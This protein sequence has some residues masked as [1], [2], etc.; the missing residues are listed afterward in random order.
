MM[1]PYALPPEARLRPSSLALALSLS[2]A[3][4]HSAVAQTPRTGAASE[5]KTWST[6]WSG[7][8][9][10]DPFADQKGNVWFVG[11][12]GNYVARLD[13]KS[14]EFKRY[15]VEDGTNPHNLVVDAKG[16]V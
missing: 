7:T 9:P 16:Q 12:V 10:R 8:R 2:V 6:P 5:M 1:N 11:Q 14:G 4:G 3:L 13:P 15:E